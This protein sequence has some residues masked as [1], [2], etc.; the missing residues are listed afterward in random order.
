[1]I[2]MQ[3]QVKKKKAGFLKKFKYL[4]DLRLILKVIMPLLELFY[5]TGWDFPFFFPQICM[6]RNM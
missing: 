2:A 6:S 4:K 5:L 3:L 1:M